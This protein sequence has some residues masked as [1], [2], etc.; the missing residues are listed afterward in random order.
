MSE[1]NLSNLVNEEDTVIS[2]AQTISNDKENTTDV[3]N[4]DTNET[5]ETTGSTDTG[6]QEG[7]SDTNNEPLLKENL[8]NV[9]ELHKEENQTHQE[10]LESN[11][12][13]TKNLEQE[14]VTGTTDSSNAETESSSVMKEETLTKNEGEIS[15]EAKNET[16]QIENG[17]EHHEKTRYSENGDTNHSDES[18]LNEV[19]SDEIKNVDNLEGESL[20]EEENARQKQDEVQKKEEQDDS[21]VLTE[22]NGA[23]KP[24]SI[25]DE[26]GI[27]HEK[28]VNETEREDNTEF[29]GEST[30][31]D[32]N[33]SETENQQIQPDSSE[34]KCINSSASEEEE[35][36]ITQDDVQN[37]REGTK[38]DQS[39]V[40][41]ETEN[42]DSKDLAEN[43]TEKDSSEDSKENFENK[44]VEPQHDTS[45]TVF[46]T[47][48]ENPNDSVGKHSDTEELDSGDAALNNAVQSEISSDKVDQGDDKISKEEEG[49]AQILVPDETLEKQQSVVENEVSDKALH[50][51]Q[52]EE[53]QGQ[54]TVSDA[55]AVD[56]NAAGVENTS[57]E[58]HS[59][60]GSQLFEELRNAIKEQVDVP[61]ED[62][63]DA[64][65]YLQEFDTPPVNENGSV[66]DENAEEGGN[67]LDETFEELLQHNANE[68]EEKINDENSGTT[69]EG[70][71]GE[72]FE[73]VPSEE[74]SAQ[75][76]ESSYGND[77]EVS[78]ESCEQQPQVT[79]KN[80][81]SIKGSDFSISKKS[82][83]SNP[84]SKL[85]SKFTTSQA[86]LPKISKTASKYSNKPSKM[87]S[88][89]NS[90]QLSKQNSSTL[91]SVVRPPFI[92]SNSQ[93]QK[94]SYSNL[95]VSQNNSKSGSK[96]HSQT[97]LFDAEEGEASIDYTKIVSALRN[98]IGN[99]KGNVNDYQKII[100]QIKA[101]E[102]NMTN[103]IEKF[104]KGNSFRI[105]QSTR[106]LLDRQ[107]KAYQI[108]VGKLRREVRRLKYQKNSV[109]DPLIEQRYFPFLPRTPYGTSAEFSPIGTMGNVVTKASDYFSLNPPPPTGNHP[110][111]GNRW[112]W[113]IGPHLSKHLPPTR[114]KTAPSSN[115][116]VPNGFV[117]KG[118]LVKQNSGD[119]VEQ[120]LLPSPPP[121][122]AK[123]NNIFVD[124]RQPTEDDNDNI[125]EA[126]F[127]F[128]G[129]KVGDRV[130]VDVQGE[131]C[132]GLLKYIGPFDARPESGVW[133]GLKLDHAIGKH[134]GVVAGK[135]YFN[136]EE[137]HGIFVKMENVSVVYKPKRTVPKRES[138]QSEQHFSQNPLTQE[139]QV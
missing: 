14:N 92:V 66:A 112:W 96:K 37:N 79:T 130:S 61:H 69:E 30:Q 122:A 27:N 23:D 113:G 32:K 52:N 5:V 17:D 11:L 94:N 49:E 16:T 100:E 101:H 115:A 103:E 82:L 54:V 62:E 104:K 42:T 67:Y 19:T 64:P 13:D 71:Y 46:V 28:S 35:F 6:S 9:E 108:L 87:A 86:S 15:S 65:N 48:N 7:G 25:N 110:E 31:S 126:K 68:N 81:S 10:N 47:S 98:E 57:D 2:V 60:A 8:N 58:T 40:S 18:N 83:T 36:S 135:R 120:S 124:K 90:K 77:F 111:S 132:F 21:K 63:E 3:N 129:L 38:N 114:P 12:I 22:E 131:K 123:L 74:K 70:N 59:E 84:R 24:K 137:N 39:E 80:K 133:C 125:W 50:E 97:S 85:G 116:P 102:E 128:R 45:A 93:S 138:V 121:L 106:V 89:A 29:T 72:D 51:N 91:P 1:T 41:Q 119:K 78:D 76:N 44:E 26:N 55:V 117:H 95:L 34:Q 127:K 136:C 88:V 105:D 20:Q 4:L 109:S 139:I 107:K 43:F 99:L 56:V 53:N 33:H 134:N 75:E 73:A 118:R